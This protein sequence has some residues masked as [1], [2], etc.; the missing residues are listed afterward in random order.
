MC[1][2]GCDAKQTACAV[3]YCCLVT[4]LTVLLLFPG[5]PASWYSWHVLCGASQQL[6]VSGAA[7]PSG[8]TLTCCLNSSFGA[9]GGRTGQFLTQD[10]P[11]SLYEPKHAAVKLNSSLQV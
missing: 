6:L 5:L 11:I 3:L 2:V 9:G 8:G 4:C 10:T 7:L 1:K